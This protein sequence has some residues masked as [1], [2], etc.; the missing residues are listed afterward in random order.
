MAT[1]L[2]ACSHYVTHA[3]LALGSSTLLVGVKEA[4]VIGLTIL[5]F[6]LALSSPKVTDTIIIIISH[7]SSSSSKVSYIAK[8]YAQEH[9]HVLT[10]C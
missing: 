8:A 5:Q 2:D 4:K 7:S 1:D 10:S 9:Q 3:L 6:T